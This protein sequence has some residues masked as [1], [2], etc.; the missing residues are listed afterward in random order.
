MNKYLFLTLICL[1]FLNYSRAGQSRGSCKNIEAGIR[2]C[3]VPG[4]YLPGPVVNKPSGFPHSPVANMEGLNNKQQS[5]PLS[6]QNILKAGPLRCTWDSVIVYDTL[7]NVILHT[8]TFDIAGH[9]LTYLKQVLLSGTWVNWTEYTYE[10][11]TAGNLV[12]SLFLIWQN[13]A[14]EN[15]YL[16]TFTYDTSGNMLTYF[17]QKWT[18][19]VWA[20][21]WMTAYAYDALG[22]TTGEVS[23][24]WSGAGWVFSYQ[25]FYSYD[26]NNNLVS[27]TMQDWASG[28]WANQIRESYTYDVRNNITG[29]LSEIWGLGVWNNQGRETYT[30]DTNGKYTASLGETWINDGWVN[31]TRSSLLYNTGGDLITTI[32]EYWNQ[33]TSAWRNV[34][35]NDITYNL[36]H[37]LLIN[38]AQIWDSGLPGWQY[39]TKTSY[40][41]DANLN[42]WI[43]IFERWLQSSWQAGMGRLDMYSQQEKI[44]TI[45]SAWQYQAKFVYIPSGTG[46][47][48]PGNPELTV[49]PN[50]AGDYLNIECQAFNRNDLLRI[51]VYDIHGRKVLQ[52]V[53]KQERTMVDVSGLHQGAYLLQLVSG[54]RAISAEFI[55]K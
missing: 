22:N 46:D 2:T 8:A 14:W 52:G 45:S 18:G 36:D 40:S 25:V 23:E 48:K 27:S 15:Y 53:M 29:Y 38:L 26:A 33:N 34:M 19:S 37:C 47:L 39:Y 13:D 43:G 20:A 24:I 35:K 9:Q 6:Y 10:Y 42:S 3:P 31:A 4:V 54:S 55:K 49:F 1:S 44:S 21:V 16:F 12:N 28:S 51:N 41:Y 11:D 17:E 5:D 32:F 7:S 30:W 50:P